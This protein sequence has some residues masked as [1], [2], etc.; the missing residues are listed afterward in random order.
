MMIYTDN[1]PV[2]RPLQ[3]CYGCLDMRASGSMAAL[4]EAHGIKLICFGVLGGP[5]TARLQKS[6]NPLPHTP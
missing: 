3:V 4:C 1:F 6:Y 5:V 2:D